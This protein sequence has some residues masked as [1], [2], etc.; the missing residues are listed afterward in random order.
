MER[1]SCEL[2][3]DGLL[4]SGLTSEVSSLSR[5]VTT[6]FKKIDEVS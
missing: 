3:E 2:L 5:K 6:F 4:E 1:K